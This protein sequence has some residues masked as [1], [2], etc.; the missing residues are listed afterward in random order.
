MS[1]SVNLRSQKGKGALW[2]RPGGRSS[3]NGD[4]PEEDG[5]ASMRSGGGGRSST[6][7]TR[8]TR[9]ISMKLL[10]G[11]GGQSISLVPPPA[12]TS[13]SGASFADDVRGAHGRDSG[14][15]GNNNT[16]SPS[17]CFAD[18]PAVVKEIS[19]RGAIAPTGFCQQGGGP[20][21]ARGGDV[22]R[23]TRK[24]GQINR[25]GVNA[26]FLIWEQ[27]KGPLWR[28]LRAVMFSQAFEMFV[29]SVILGNFVAIAVETD[30]RSK[31]LKSDPG[32]EAYADASTQLNH[33]YYLN[34]AFLVF[35][36][37]EC[38]C[39]L[40]AMREQFFQYKWN[41][42]DLFIVVVGLIGEVLETA[43][44][45]SGEAANVQVLRSLR[46]IR[47]LRATR[48][49]VSFQELYMLISGL[50]NCFR[51]LL[52]AAGLVFMMLTI[53]SIISVEYVS[54]LMPEL[55]E[56]GYYETC[57]WCAKAF[58]NILSAN[59]TYF[60]I[61]TGDGWSKLARPLI[62]RHPWTAFILSGVIFTMV[63]G[64]LNLITAVIVDT[65]TQARSLDIMNLAHRKKREREEAWE[66][67]TGLCV[68]LDK[69]MSGDISLREL[70][71]GVSTIPELDAYLAI[72]GVEDDDI[73]MVFDILDKDGD[74]Q[75]S[76]EEFALQLYR[77]KTQEVGTN[78]HI[79]K[80]M[81]EEMRQAVKEVKS[82]ASEGSMDIQ[83]FTTLDIQ[84]ASTAAVF[85]LGPQLNRGDSMNSNS[86]NNSQTAPT[87]QLGSKRPDEVCIEDDPGEE[88]R[89]SQ[90]HAPAPSSKAQKTVNTEQPLGLS[91]EQAGVGFD[92][93]KPV[94]P[95]GQTCEPF[96][97]S[98]LGTS[99]AKHG[100]T[101]AKYA[102]VA[103]QSSGLKKPPQLFFDATGSPS[104]P[105]EPQSNLPG[106]VD[107]TSQED[108]IDKG[109][110]GANK[111]EDFDG[112]V[113]DG[114]VPPPPAPLRPLSASSAA[115]KYQTV[116]PPTSTMS[117]S[118]PNEPL[119]PGQIH[120]ENAPN[121]TPASLDPGGLS[122]PG[123]KSSMDESIT[124]VKPSVK[125]SSL[126]DTKD[127]ALKDSKDTKDSGIESED[128]LSDA[129]SMQS[130]TPTGSPRA[131]PSANNS[132]T[133]QGPKDG[134]SDVEV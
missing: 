115:G 110:R 38:A 75:V 36:T 5:A 50:A 130:H 74:G 114:L 26:F 109:K 76:H 120:S 37:T 81:L 51:S 22:G 68:E 3:Q 10:D 119:I 57:Y 35:Y 80:H 67:F 17:A 27:D 65:A 56:A 61:I 48:I 28:F 113:P 101:G 33:I 20:P 83:G 41:L 94:K 30:V 122:V 98:S 70:K 72:M 32:T 131:G 39:R 44:Q 73:D 111:Q 91:K 92:V 64:L 104:P 69:D 1:R 54:P 103:S 43:L 53:W 127:S 60:Q 7:S 117:G 86:G 12:K 31:L 59:L 90:Q 108:Q 71:A 9:A 49:L 24:T 45:D 89:S 2:A 124:L 97:Q 134:I 100:N 102:S 25:Y 4:T 15:V 133:L 19:H 116:P 107:L 6:H 87:F 58:D 96:D 47:L 42:F 18:E 34:T 93:L 82:R 79:M 99:F 62:E 132:Q 29:G 16:L 21:T 106:F 63:F 112:L 23:Q 126:K 66:C 123:L 118:A 11:G 46:M 95:G 128:E 13:P 52:W 55:D 40:Y 129:C 88:K 78:V 77:M 14:V 84:T 105:P 121:G 8:S 85:G 125:P